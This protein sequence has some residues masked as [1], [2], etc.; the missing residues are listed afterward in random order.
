MT[1]SRRPRH[2][3]RRRR[4]E[5]AEARRNRPFNPNKLYRDPR[6]GRCMGVCAGIADYFDVRPGVVRLI[7]IIVTVMSGIWPGVCAYFI[8]G[9]ML[10]VKPDEIYEK[11]EEDEFW[12]KARNH[13]DYTRVDL[14]KRFDDIERRTR[15][16]EAYITSKRFR[17]DRELR[18]LED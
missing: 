13:P 1:R 5:D 14:N 9:F 10:D 18:S 2:S 12:R 15:D 3:R 7:T 8:L 11:P 4:R 17:L 6:N 16:M